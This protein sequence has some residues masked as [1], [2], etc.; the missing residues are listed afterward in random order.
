MGHRYTNAMLTIIAIAL[1]VIAVQQLLSSADAQNASCGVQ[2]PCKVVNVTYDQTVS[3]WK[4]C[5]QVDW[6]CY[7]VAERK[8]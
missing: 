8:H 3:Q 1:I 5:F 6:A 2:A 7:I 4:N